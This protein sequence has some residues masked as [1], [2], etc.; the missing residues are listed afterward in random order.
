[1]RPLV[2]VRDESG[3]R[4][5]V[6][7]GRRA[8]R[9]S[10]HKRIRLRLQT[11]RLSPGPHKLVITARDAAG[12]LGRFGFDVHSLRARLAPALRKRPRQKAGALFR[13]G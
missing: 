1:V 7:V 9:R 5:E 13:C 8:V 12:N 3:V 11:G 4:M 6:R 10:R 2:R